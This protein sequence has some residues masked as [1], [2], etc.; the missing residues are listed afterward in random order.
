MDLPT[1]F[2]NVANIIFFIANMRLIVGV[3]KDRRM[4]RGF[5][6][7]GSL[8]TLLGT[9]LVLFYFFFLRIWLSFCLSLTTFGLWLTVT[10]YVGR[11]KGRGMKKW[12]RKLLRMR[13]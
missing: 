12:V 7:F 11:K 6:F 2:L 10:I 4:L 3:Y 5:D 8:L 13:L 1:T 9:I